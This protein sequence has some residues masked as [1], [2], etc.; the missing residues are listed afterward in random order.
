M[1]ELRRGDD[2]PREDGKY[3][4]ERA[5]SPAGLYEVQNDCGCIWVFVNWKDKWVRWRDMNI[6]RYRK[7]DPLSYLE[8]AT[9]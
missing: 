2:P 3:V 8:G 4:I 1:T 7:F 9:P 5:G 6:T